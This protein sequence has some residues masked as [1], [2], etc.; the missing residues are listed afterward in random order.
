M[1][2]VVFHLPTSFNDGSDIPPELIEMLVNRVIQKT[3]G[4]TLI[5]CEGAWRDDEGYLHREVVLRIMT[6]IDE[7]EVEDFVEMVDLSLKTAFRQKAAW[8]EVDGKPS[9]R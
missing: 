5:P 8:I 2:T 6:G 9:I 3:G 4:I 7:A 1:I